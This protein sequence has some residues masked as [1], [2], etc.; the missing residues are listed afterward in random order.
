MNKVI[1]SQIGISEYDF[2]KKLFD[3]F[4]FDGLESEKN[5]INA[6][7]EQCNEENGQYVSPAYEEV[8]YAEGF[9]EDGDDEFEFIEDY[10]DDFINTKSLTKIRTSKK[11]QLTDERLWLISPK[12]NKALNT[13]FKRSETVTLHPL[14]EYIEGTKVKLSTEYGALVLEVVLSENIRANCVVVN[15]NTLGLNKLTPSLVSNKGESACYQEVKVE[16]ERV[17]E[18]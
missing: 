7:L 10:D 12:S 4:G 3:A 18:S 14:L 9:G 11:N 2:T 1:D 15:S 5:Y 16:I 17:M 8:P 13:Q 6:W